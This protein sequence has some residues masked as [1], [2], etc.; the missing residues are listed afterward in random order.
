MISWNHLEQTRPCLETLFRSTRTPCR[1]FIVD[2]GSTPAVRAFLA[3]VK[4][5]GEIREVVL[6][7]N[8]SNEGFPRAVNRGIRASSA[9]FVCLLNNDLRFAAGWLEE[10]LEVARAGP[11][12]G[13]VNPTSNTFGNV[14]PDGLPLDAY[15]DRLRARH[16]RY[17][18]V[19]MC[20]GFCILTKREVLDRLGGLSEEVERIFFEDEDFSIRVQQAG[21]RCV[22]AHAAYVFHAEHQTVKKMP[23]R[24]ALFVRN[25]RWCHA[26]WGRWVRM[27]WPRFT[28]LT[29]GSEELR[30]WLEEL[31]GWARRRTHVYVY[32]PLPPRMTRDALFGSVGLVPHA[33]IRWH[34]V[35]AGW[36]RWAA[37]GR[38]LRRR[39]KRFDIIVAPDERWRRALERLAWVHRAQVVPAAHAEELEAQWERSRSRL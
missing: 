1:L 17:T 32:C 6:L 3:G 13:A 21:F 24:E 20:I 27:A 10:M 19:G 28:P 37:A 15:A 5:Q 33:D 8:D 25:Q 2:N 34:P 36:A 30:R 23:E 35:A 11:S 16:G 31:L 29:P 22:V 7:Q 26:K 9:P 4:P 38:I 39:K 14:P 12:I 18:E